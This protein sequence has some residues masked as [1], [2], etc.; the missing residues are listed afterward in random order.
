MGNREAPVRD[1]RWA[2]TLPA[3]GARELL[4][5]V[6]FG[7]IIGFYSRRRITGLEHLRSVSG[8]VI[9]VANHCSH[10]DT[11]V[12]LLSLPGRR[13]RRS[14]VAAA[15]DYF[16]ARRL[17]AS[18]VSLAFGTVPVDRRGRDG[19]VTTNLKP[20][21]D[22]G[23]NLV[24]FAEG[25]RSRSGRVGT[26]RPGAAVLASLHQLP[27]VPIYIS[28]TREAMP[29]GRRWMV[30]PRN[31]GRLARHT[32]AVKFGAPIPSTRLEDRY[33]VMERVR[34]FMASCGADTTPDPKLAARRAA[35]I[36]VQ[37]A[38]HLS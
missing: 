5:R 10:V 29:T 21:I 11:P 28:G 2:R 32:I 31:G 16:Y 13:R 4:L 34:L 25:T 35:A 26:L 15:A 14:A 36:E 27:I 38:V 19:D 1:R 24:V 6:V 12:V 22:G 3:R 9:F 23:W 37:P 30:R 33:E 8:P 18:A 20:L 7:S 17:L